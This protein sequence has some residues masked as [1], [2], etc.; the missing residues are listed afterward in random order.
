MSEN[1]KVVSGKIPTDT[2]E[3]FLEYC[4][5]RGI[6]KSEAVRRFVTAGLEEDSGGETTVSTDAQRT[7]V[8]AGVVVLWS[9]I[10]G[11]AM[12]FWMYL[13]TLGVPWILSADTFGMLAGVFFVIGVT[14]AL[15]LG[16]L[17]LGRKIAGSLPLGQAPGRLLIG[18][19]RE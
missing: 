18:S 4:E 1:T 10:G 8:T 19:G 16:L 9:F 11:F 13:R 17:K 12:L 2:H 5:E 7:E 15:I 3:K 6:S 14:G